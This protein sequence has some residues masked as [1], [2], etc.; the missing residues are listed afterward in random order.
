MPLPKMSL[1]SNTNLGG[2][3]VDK[4]TETSALVDRFVDHSDDLSS[5]LGLFNLLDYFFCFL[6]QES[7]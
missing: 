1:R 7:I 4:E 5:D 6:N 3:D 2:G